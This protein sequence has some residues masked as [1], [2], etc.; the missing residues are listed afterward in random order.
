MKPG[1]AC[2]N[3]MVH[4]YS[5][6]VTHF[7]LIYGYLPSNGYDNHNPPLGVKS[8]EILFISVKETT[9]FRLGP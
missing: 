7:A 1:T 4:M 5:H 2:I 9:I 8:Q 6:P 3:V